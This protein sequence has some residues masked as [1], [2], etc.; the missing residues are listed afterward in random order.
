MLENFKGISSSCLSPDIAAN[1]LNN[2]LIVFFVLLFNSPLFN[3]RS[4]ICSQ[5]DALKVTLPFGYP[6]ESNIRLPEAFN[7]KLP[8]SR[9]VLLI[10]RLEILVMD[11]VMEKPLLLDLEELLVI[12]MN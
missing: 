3:A 6:S 8:H 4:K 9:F 7:L 10:L 11:T 12:M 2:V 1:K 5:L